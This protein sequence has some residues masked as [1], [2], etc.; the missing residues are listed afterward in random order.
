MN[1]RPYVLCLMMTS[2]DGKILGEHWGKS[3]RVKALLKTFEQTHEK[4]GIGAWIVGRTTMEKD[5]TDFAKPVL[6]KGHHELD[7]ADFV[8]AGAPHAKSFAIAVDGQAKL[9]W[10]QATMQG[11]QVITILTEAVPD[12]YLAHL[13]D[14]GVSYVFA[15]KTAV[16]LT[17]ALRKLWA[18][19]GIEKLM[20]EGGGHLN[21][22]FLN[23]GLIDELHQLLLPL[24]DGTANTSTLFDVAADAKKE[25]ATLLKLAS[26]ARLDDDVLHLT[27]QIDRS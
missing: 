15:G 3:P 5:F 20:L 11:D 16:D 19:F 17:V 7:R 1:D 8:A 4:L 22:T 27:Y 18:L 25:G 9:G 13:Q 14:I 6:K 24:A 23:E 12:A 10:Q 2:V 21:G 26:V